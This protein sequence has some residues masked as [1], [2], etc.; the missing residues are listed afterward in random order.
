MTVS[1]KPFWVLAGML[2]VLAG[3]DALRVG[4][5]VERKG[6]EIVVCGQLY[7]TTAPVVLWT[8][9][10]GYDAYR[11]E[12]RFAPI[13]ESSW[14]KTKETTQIKSPN[15]FGMRAEGLPSD[16][17]ERVRGGGWDIDT[18]RD[19]V[20]QFVIHFD[21]CGLSKTCF[22]VLHDERCLSV[23]FMLD[24]DGTIYQTLD[25]KERAWHAT[26]ANTR[27]V[28]IEIANIGDFRPGGA[29]NPRVARW[30]SKG[31]DSHT[32]ITIPDAAGGL[33]GSGLRDRS[34][35]LRPS[36]DEPVVGVVQGRE[37][38]MYDLTPQ[39]YDSLV[40][41]TA[42]LCTILPKIRCDYPREPSGVVVNHKLP[43]DALKGYHGVLG[44]Y[45]V[46][47]NKTDPGPA[48]QWDRV[49]DGARALMAK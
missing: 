16:V 1:R 34:L 9:P 26:I 27:S 7:H 14:E 13:D 48:F 25:L 40:K 41:L 3:A 15:R 36:R 21:A 28:G 32:R 2:P 29:D 30:Y 23:H 6:D 46:Q 24:L 39:Q 18:L 5:K 22:R 19:V 8:D 47:T 43:D 44:H 38:A 31:P 17:A 20:D 11:V 35:T 12:R 49:I 37:Q 33:Q 42:T 45:H 10:G 4:Q